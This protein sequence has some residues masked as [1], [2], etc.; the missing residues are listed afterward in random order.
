MAIA[1][2]NCRGHVD[3]IHGRWIKGLS[4]LRIADGIEMLSSSGRVLVV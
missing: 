3:A 1:A 4:K 2:E